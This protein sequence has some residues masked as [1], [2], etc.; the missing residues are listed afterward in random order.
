MLCAVFA[1]AVKFNE[2]PSMN[3]KRAEFLGDVA[4]GLWGRRALEKRQDAGACGSQAVLLGCL[5]EVIVA[6]VQ[7][8]ESGA[9]G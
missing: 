3:K 9:P 2:C 5:H 7:S 4:D 6:F 8:P 1:S